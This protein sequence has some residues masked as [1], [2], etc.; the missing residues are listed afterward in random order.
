LAGDYERLLARYLPALKRLAACYEARPHAR[1]DLLQEILLAIWKALPGFRGDC[2]ERT[3][4]FRVAHN[5]CLSHVWRR[6]QRA[7]V[8]NE[9]VEVADPGG[10]PEQQ[11][12]DQRR[13]EALL[14]A[15]RRLAL[16]YR[17]AISLVLEDLPVA[18]IAAVLG[19]SENNVAVRLNRARKMLRAMLEKGSS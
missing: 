5:R 2:S 7:G 4:V 8:E 9:L 6:T 1:E 11:V 14:D 10:S 12:I 17:Q 13:R 18:E 16:P 19:I 15:I 3:F